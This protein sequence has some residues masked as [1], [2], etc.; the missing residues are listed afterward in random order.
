MSAETIIEVTN[1][2]QYF[3]WHDYGLYLYI[4]E[5][6]LPENIEQCTIHIKAMSI[7]NDYQLPQ[8]IHLVSAVCSFKCVPKC[9]F[10]KPLTLE[11]QHC[12]KQKNVHKLCFIRS[13]SSANPNFQV[14]PEKSDDHSYFESFFPKYTKYGLI[15]LNKFCQVGIGQR[16]T[17]ERDYC[18]IVYRQYLG[19]DP[20]CHKIFF[21]I[22]WN[23]NAHNKVQ[24]S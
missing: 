5:N 22:L 19:G 13:I 7:T 20:Q 4:P 15:E 14:I 21:A 16:G 2:E 17:N 10:L 24:E 23:T 9:Q 18:A 12:A 6:S 11:M 8:D 1:S 3:S